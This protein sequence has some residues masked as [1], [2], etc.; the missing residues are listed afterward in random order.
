MELGT[1]YICDIHLIIEWDLL[2]K[3]KKKKKSPTAY[4]TTFHIDSQNCQHKQQNAAAGL[5]L[6]PSA[7]GHLQGP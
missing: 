3:K 7:E 1:A 4:A 5:C 6:L 2:E